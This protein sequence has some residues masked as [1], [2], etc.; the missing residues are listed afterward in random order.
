[1]RRRNSASMSSGDGMMSTVPISAD[2]ILRSSETIQSVP[3]PRQSAW[4]CPTHARM[5]S[6]SRWGSSRFSPSV[7]RMAWR[8]V[9]VD[10]AKRSAARSSQVD[11]AVPPPASRWL[12][13]SLA[14]P[15]VTLSATTRLVPHGGKKVVATSP[16]ATTANC[17]PSRMPSMAA[18]AA[19]RAARM[20]V[21]G[22]LIEPE[23]ST[24]RTSA[25]WPA[26]GPP[27][28]APPLAVTV[29]MASIVV[30]P[31]ARYSFWNTSSE[32][33]LMLLPPVQ[34]WG[35]RARGDRGRRPRPRR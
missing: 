26:A 4:N 31:S 16:P 35:D 7:R 12:T 27:E 15:R 30:A 14:W 25:A 29:T 28:P 19:L 11:M 5:A 20:R 32:N 34:G 10:P 13:A 23:V 17:T 33:S 21:E 24:I 22:A 18:A 9:E 8:I 2:A 1:M 6:S 3:T